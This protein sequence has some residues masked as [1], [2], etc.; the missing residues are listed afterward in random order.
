MNFIEQIQRKLFIYRFI[1][2]LHVCCVRYAEVGV[3]V[4]GASGESE[5]ICSLDQIGLG[6][7]YKLQIPVN[8]IIILSYFSF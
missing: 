6:A 8:K 7:G 2:L 1:F 4:L 3:E 5:F